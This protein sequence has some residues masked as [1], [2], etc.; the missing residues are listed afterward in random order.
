MRISP[1]P[2]RSEEHLSNG[3]TGPEFA[4]LARE[5][6][7]TG[8]L[9]IRPEN[10]EAVR[11]VQSQEKCPLATHSKKDIRLQGISGPTSTSF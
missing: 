7:R 5:A 4:E 11:V 3:V 9:D 1:G 10:I 6:C 2:N 8:I